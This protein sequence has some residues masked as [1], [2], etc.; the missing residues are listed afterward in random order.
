MKLLPILCAAIVTFAALVLPTSGARAEDSGNAQHSAKDS[1]NATGRHGAKTPQNRTAKVSGR[2]SHEQMPNKTGSAP[3]AQQLKLPANATA[4]APSR[5]NR[6]T[7]AMSN[8]AKK[9][10]STDEAIVQNIK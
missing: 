9:M 1:G 2:Q 3:N 8:I 7:R 5:T 6:T 10:D 4:A